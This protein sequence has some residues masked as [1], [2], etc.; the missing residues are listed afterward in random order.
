[1]RR[2]KQKGTLYWAYKPRIQAIEALAELWHGTGSAEALTS[3]AAAMQSASMEGAVRARYRPFAMLLESLSHLSN[4]QRAV[5]T[6]EL[7]ADRYLRSAKILARD[8]AKEVNATS[9]FD[10][11]TAITHKIADISDVDDVRSIACL[12]L[13]LPLP[14]PVFAQT[15]DAVGV[16]RRPFAEK[17]SP[18]VVVAFTSFLLDG[19][20]F[21]QPQTV[22]PSVV[23]DLTVEVSISQW[24]TAALELR[25]EPISV[26]PPAS[27]ELPVFSMTRPV[28]DPPFSARQQ[29][30]MVLLL[31]PAVSARPLE[32]T[33]RARFLPDSGDCLV[34]VEGQRNLLAQN[35]DP[36]RNPISGY[37][38]IDR[39]LHDIRDQCRR[40]SAMSDRELD[41]FLLL[42]KMQVFL[43][44]NPQIGSE[45]DVH[46]HVGAGITDLSFRGVRLELKVDGSHLMTTDDGDRFVPQTAQYVVGSDRRL[47]ILCLLDCSPKTAPPGSPANDIVLK[48]VPPPTGGKWPVYIAVVIVRGSLAKPSSMS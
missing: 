5:R 43:R 23:H 1:M 21:K 36:I 47:G 35:Y 3:A 39:R 24:P 26:E 42:L 16:G 44:S 28:G 31:P 38:V 48:V 7:D 20:P 8:V 4:W 12:V 29:G 13:G 17:K 22:E 19:S 40:G 46:P 14:L 32:F 34:F 18:E 9:G 37:E 45:L 41:N 25:L 11:L 10:K 2:T 6:A 30:R 33:Y 15:P 27:Y